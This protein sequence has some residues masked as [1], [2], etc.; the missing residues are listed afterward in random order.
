[1]TYEMHVISAEPNSSLHVQVQSFYP[2]YPLL[3]LYYSIFR[4]TTINFKCGDFISNKGVV[5]LITF[6]IAIALLIFSY[7]T[8]GKFVERVFG[9]N[10]NRK[11]PAYAN[12]DDV[13][14]LPMHKQKNAL[15]QL[16]NIAGTGP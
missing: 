5:N 11:T 6:L 2:S 13:D 12:R 4:L 8:Y 16:L 9:P 15:I 14:Y 10:E 1:V 7:F 3:M